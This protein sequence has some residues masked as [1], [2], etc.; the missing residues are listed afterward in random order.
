M[1]PSP[2]SPIGSWWAC[3]GNRSRL[4]PLRRL[5]TAR[6]DLHCH[7]PAWDGEY[8]PAEV[9]R[10]AHAAG[11]AAIALTDHDTTAGVPEAARAGEPLGVRIV[12]GC[13]FSVKAPWGELHLLAY[14]LPPC[15]ARLAE[16]LA[17]PRAPRHPRAQPLLS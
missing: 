1:P 15:G 3:S 11:L 16:F 12:F 14:F 7:S 2:S 13:A 5:P 10:R 17:G 4:G 8:P 9:A 6:V